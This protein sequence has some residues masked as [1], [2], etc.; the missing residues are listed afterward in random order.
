MSAT[1]RNLRPTT[2][3][4]DHEVEEGTWVHLTDI[5]WSLLQQAAKRSGIDAAVEVAEEMA[6]QVRTAQRLRREA[7]CGP[8]GAA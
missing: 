1:V 2:R 8:D 3:P 4:Y 6:D 7:E 5:E